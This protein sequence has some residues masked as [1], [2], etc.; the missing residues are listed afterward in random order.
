M[1]ID[2]FLFFNEK[3]LTELRVK[4]L[5]KII[6]VFVV[7]EANITH[8]GK[9]KDWNF[10]NIL[11][12]DLKEYSPKIYNIMLNIQKFMDGK[13]PTGK[14]LIYSE[15]RGDAGCEALELV[16]RSH[17]YESFNYKDHKKT[18]SLK[19]TIISG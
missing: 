7:L 15:F 17:G 6:D 9:K 18:K 12:N 2:S 19:Y 13:K 5:D 3:E 4:Y 1:L 11:K 14:I 16:L 8:Q 10:P